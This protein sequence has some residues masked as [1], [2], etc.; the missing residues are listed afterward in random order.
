MEERRLTVQKRAFPSK[1]RARVHT[2]VLS[3][4]GVDERGDL[5]VWTT[6]LD[7][8]ITVSAYGDSMV[9]PDTIRLSEEDLAG[10]GAD[11]GDEV[12]V[13]KARPLTDQV[14]DS[15]HAAAG[16]V[17]SGFEDVKGKIAKTIEPVATKAQTAAQDAYSRVSKDLPTREDLSNAIASA[18]KKLASNV[19]PDEAGMLISLLYE[20]KGAIRS[21]QIPAGSGEHAISSLGLPEGVIVIAISRDRDVLAIPKKGSTVSAG[22]RLYL[23]GK[24]DLLSAAVEKLGV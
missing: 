23:I 1:G 3:D 10:L 22:D 8:W 9:Q 21:V 17:A 7:R 14:K 24:E 5:D 19:T 18:K 20:N 16:Q 6:G 2:S 13:K 4:L 11:N 12:I 15:A